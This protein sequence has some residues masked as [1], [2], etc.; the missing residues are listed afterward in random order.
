[1]N[2]ISRRKYEF[3]KTHKNTLSEAEKKAFD[4][5]EQQLNES[6]STKTEIEPTPQKVFR[7]HLP[8]KWTKTAF[9]KIWETQQKKKL[10]VNQ[11]NAKEL[12]ALCQYFARIPGKLDLNKGL[13]I[14]GGTGTGKTSALK[15]FHRMGEMIWAAEQDPIMKFSWA[16][17]I[18]LVD[19]FEDLSTD[20][21]LFFQQY[22]G[23][24]RMF[25]DFGQENDAS[26]F[27]LK[28]LM[29]EIMEKRYNA[30]IWRTYITTNLTAEQIL[31]KYGQRVHSRIFE[32][33]NVL[34]M[35][36]DDY[37]IKNND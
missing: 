30:P 25:D 11:N 2:L 23:M 3:L 8:L 29:K 27:G 14:M 10:V 34:P 15:A 5:Y 4:L 26:R 20:K 17:C 31:T 12:A 6:V 9:V 18:D 16:N 33:F 35:V 13:L 7:T 21:T 19:E 32:M 37:R 36:G 1:M 22:R 24:H 28:N